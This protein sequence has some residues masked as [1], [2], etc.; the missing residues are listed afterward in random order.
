MT[1]LL[2]SEVFP[3]MKG[4]SGRWLWELYRR[5]QVD[6]LRVVAS[7]SPGAEEFDRTHDLNVRRMPLR[8]SSWGV[9]GWG[10]WDYAGA[11]RRLAVAIRERRPDILHCGKSLP[12]GFLAWLVRRW[13]G[14]PYLCYAHGEELMLARTSKDLGWLT[15]RA[16]GGADRVIANSRHTQSILER[17]W[18][19][20]AERIV[21]MHPGVDTGTFVPAR[22]DARVRARLGWQGR[23]VVLTVGALQK[24]KGQDMM[25]RA[26]PIIRKACPDVLYA[27][28]GEGWEQTYLEDLVAELGVR[29]AV[30]FRGI[31]DDRGLIECYQQCDLFVL[32]NRQ[33]G[34][35][36]EGFGIVLLEAQACGKP[37]VAGASGGTVETLDA[38]HTGLVVPC[39][40]PVGLADTVVRLLE[41]PELRVGMGAR[42]R[43]WVERFDWDALGRQARGLFKQDPG[44]APQGAEGNRPTLPGGGPQCLP[45]RARHAAR[46][47]GDGR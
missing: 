44:Q 21:V 2:L 16:L 26:L 32:A 14:I 8:F 45:G 43:Q 18:G 4:G 34:W 1:I 6:Q 19:I 23:R 5:L 30:Q 13:W 41:D 27:V 11:L 46:G 36:F 40:S 22:P 33:V 47:R 20:P 10:A 24:R 38:P 25:I 28:A 29:D 15:R 37:V 9:L 35:D 7:A 17:D 12:E 42:G 3:P 39:E 31:P